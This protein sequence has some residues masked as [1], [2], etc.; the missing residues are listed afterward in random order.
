VITDNR[1][2]PFWG[3]L[4][5]SLAD[6]NLRLYQASGF[7][8]GS[9]VTAS[10]ST[11]DNVELVHQSALPPGDYVLV[12][13][14]ASTTTTTSYALAWHSLP[15]VT[16]AATVSTAREIDLQAGV[17]TITRTGDTTLPLFVPLTMGGSAIS[18]THFQALA[19]SVTIAAGQSSTT[20]DVTPIADS[21]AQGD[22]SV[23]VAIAADFA[24]VRDAVQ[25]A[26]ITIQDKPADAWRFAQFTA[27]ELGDPAISSDN[28]DP[29]HDGLANLLEYALAL[30]PHLSS[31]STAVAS[32]SGGYLTLSVTKN[33]AATELVWAAEVTDDLVTWTSA[34]IVTNTS[35]SF[36]VRDTVLSSSAFKRFIR[37]KITR[38]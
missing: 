29:D 33:S 28:S 36:V 20:L 13:E 3:N 27:I 9:Q 10:L 21:I 11:V 4:S 2:G 31:P 14:N 15:A 26:V 38:P 7:A 37:L 17:V 24:L 12:V 25:S 8:L 18:G 35:G 1:N 34:V 19:T 16:V 5:S 23:T 32:T 22:R 6:L 30:D